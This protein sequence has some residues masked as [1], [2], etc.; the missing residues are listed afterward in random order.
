MLL[1][2]TAAPPPTKNTSSTPTP[3]PDVV[4]YL[5]PRSWGETLNS[6]KKTDRVGDFE[7]RVMMQVTWV[8]WFVLSSKTTVKTAKLHFKS[9]Y[10]GGLLPPVHLLHQVRTYQEACPVEAMRAVNTFRRE[11]RG[12]AAANSSLNFDL[13]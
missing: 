8:V 6:L 7:T 11:K 10:M 2:Q 3:L 4:N 5:K 1:S 9:D 12:S 13:Y